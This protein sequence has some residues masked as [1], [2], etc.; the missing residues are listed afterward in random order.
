MIT[1]QYNDGSYLEKVEDWHVGDSIWKA[2]KVFQMIE[3]HQLSP[4]TVYDIGCGAGEI[5]VQL[6]QKI[7]D[8]V[9]F[10]GFDIS[11]QAISLA[12]PRENANLTFFNEDFNSVSFPSPDILLLLDV[13][14]HIPDYFG[15]LESIRQKTDWVIF[16]IP[17]DIGV[18]TVLKKSDYMM[19]MRETYGHL[20][21]FTKETAISTLSDIGFEIVDFFYTNDFE[22]TDAMIPNR[23]K[24][25]IQYK[26]RKLIF[27]MNQDLA[28]SVFEQ[29]N[30]L[31]LARGD[32][33][34][35][36]S[37]DKF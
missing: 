25:R 2:S 31:L 26:M 19:Y 35:Y 12:T 27:R 15:F 13:F 4:N 23:F 37:S 6:Q 34:K 24:S 10:V 9:K 21:F 11:P 36:N 33:G 14:E 16:H 17:L 28:A 22:I 30:L 3:S 1:N 7:N 5:L 29:F 20:H 18:K 32:L 8:N